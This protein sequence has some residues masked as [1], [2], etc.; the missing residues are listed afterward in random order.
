[1]PDASDDAKA[2]LAAHAKSIDALHEKLAATAGVDKAKLAQ[3]VS[4][5]KAA[6]QTFEDDALGCMN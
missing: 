3:A 4:K 2:S 5:Y 6:H 1:M